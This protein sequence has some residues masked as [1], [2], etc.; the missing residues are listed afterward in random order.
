MCRGQPDKVF[1]DTETDTFLV[2]KDLWRPA[3]RGISVRPPKDYRGPCKDTSLKGQMQRHK[4][5]KSCFKHGGKCFLRR[6]LKCVRVC[7]FRNRLQRGCISVT[8]ALMSICVSNK[9]LNGVRKEADRQSRLKVTSTARQQTGK[10]W[11]WNVKKKKKR[12]ANFYSLSVQTLL[13]LILA[14]MAER[15][16]VLNLTRYC[17]LAEIKMYRKPQVFVGE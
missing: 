6:Y 13:Y 16:H 15:K 9:N 10:L 7:V 4:L 1:E 8:D 5:P 11:C 12:A 3:S 17:F 14:F 2:V